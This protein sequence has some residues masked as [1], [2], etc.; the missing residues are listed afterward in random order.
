MS[1]SF[2]G[3]ISIGGR[4]QRK[5]LPAFLKAVSD[6]CYSYY[7]KTVEDLKE[8]IQDD[9]VLEIEEAEASYG[10]FE[11]LEKFCEAHDL[12][13]SR[14]SD[15]YGEYDAETAYWAPGMAEAIFNKADKH[16]SA[17]INKSEVLEWIKAVKNF[18]AK[19]APLHINDEDEVTQTLAK[20]ALQNKKLNKLSLLTHVIESQCPDTSKIP[21]FEIVD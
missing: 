11:A 17:V 5:D 16:S 15:S 9:G 3:R 19:D 7:P 2:Y 21:A 4:I 10:H 1:D 20:Y 8:Y 12:T 13:Y 14:D 6:G 18:R